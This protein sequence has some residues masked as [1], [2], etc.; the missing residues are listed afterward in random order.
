M[1]SFRLVSF[2]R[3]F[4]AYS[5]ACFVGC[6]PLFAVVTAAVS[7]LTIGGRV[8]LFLAR[9]FYRWKTRSSRLALRVTPI[10]SSLGI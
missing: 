4:L 3:A 1:L 2:A 7:H 9:C 5:C 6:C 10:R 8:V